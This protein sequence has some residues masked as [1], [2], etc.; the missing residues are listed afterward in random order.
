[1]T[2]TIRPATA[3]DAPEV[4]RLIEQFA[5][6]L[7]GLG[8]TDDLNFSQAAYMRDGFGPNPAFQGLIAEL[9]GTTVGYLLYHFG[10]DT[11]RARLNL[12][13]IDLYVDTQTRG[14]GAGKALM[15]EAVQICKNAGGNGLFWA[16][17]DKNQAALEFYKSLGA[18]VTK[19]LLFMRL[20]V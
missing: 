5:E 10:Y 3:E 8:D 14:H 11:D 18:S 4:G 19:D 6:Y 15:L 12:H 1:M 9:E 20:E 13:V 16:V 17:F 7:R 2:V